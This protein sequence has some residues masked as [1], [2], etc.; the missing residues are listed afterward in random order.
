MTR[1]GLARLL[2]VKTRGDGIDIALTCLGFLLGVACTLVT[3]ALT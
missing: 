2:G 3:V 1:A